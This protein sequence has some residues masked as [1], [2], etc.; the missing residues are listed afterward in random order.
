MS[1]R[2]PKAKGDRL[3]RAVVEALRSAGIEAR[4]QPL[5]G[6]LPFWKGDVTCDL[7]I[8]GEVTFECKSRKSFKTI[9]SW[10]GPHDGLV[11]KANHEEP[12]VLMRMKDFVK[13]AG[14]ER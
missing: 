14:G 9:Y 2:N 11:L 7:P 12:L 4:R 6:A 10:L 8:L 5:S 3:E 1:L 13:L